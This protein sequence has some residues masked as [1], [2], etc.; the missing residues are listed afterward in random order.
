MLEIVIATKEVVEQVLRKL[1]HIERKI[2]MAATKQ[3]LDNA[4]SQVEGVVT[5]LG[6][7]LTTTIKDL[8][9]K[10]GS[11]SSTPEDLQPEV[12]RLNAIANSL[13]NFDSTVKNADPGPTT[14][15]TPPTA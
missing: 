11:G 9:D 13:A 15:T 1:H 2:D 5:T 14:P 7:D 3:D 4:V 8:T 6:T 12:D 10:I